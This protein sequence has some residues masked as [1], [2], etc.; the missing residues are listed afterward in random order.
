MGKRGN[1]FAILG[2]IFLILI[3]IA[4]G[5]SYYFYNYYTFKTIRVCVGGEIESNFTDFD[6]R[7]SEFE[8]VLSCE[9]AQ[10]CL[11]K[12]GNPE[13]EILE[14]DYPPFLKGTFNEIIFE[15]VLCE[16]SCKVRNI[17]GLDLESEDFNIEGLEYCE[18]YETEILIEI[19]G[20]EAFEVWQFIEKNK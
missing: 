17:R 5:L 10:D 16:D 6:E 14:G 13:K 20:R 2:V 7:F 12:I 18:D 8:N 3:L 19:G 9:V 11:D 4:G 15:A 1:I